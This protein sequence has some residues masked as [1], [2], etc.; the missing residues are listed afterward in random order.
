MIATFLALLTAA[1]TL[2]AV[3]YAVVLLVLDT[4][5]GLAE[6]DAEVAARTTTGPVRV[7]PA[8]TDDHMAI[9]AA[10]TDAKGRAL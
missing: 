3:A 9:A 7:H 5:K 6:L 1:L 2:A 10:V 4:E 8:P